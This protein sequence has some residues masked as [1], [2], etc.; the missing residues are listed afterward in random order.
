MIGSV[1]MQKIEE[2]GKQSLVEKIT[3]GI[4]FQNPYNIMTEKNPEIIETV[5]DNHK[6]AR[7]AYQKLW[8]DISEHFAEFIRS[9]ESLNMQDMDDNMPAGE[10][11]KQ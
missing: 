8:I 2:K 10:E 5:D 1:G 6:I 4:E 7:E 9:I 11:L 3:H